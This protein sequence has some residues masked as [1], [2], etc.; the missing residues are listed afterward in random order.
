MFWRAVTWPFRSGTY[1]SIT[2]GKGVE[3]IGGDP[4]QGQLDPDEL[5]VGLALAVNTLLEAEFD[6]VVLLQLTL[7]VAGGLGVEVVELALQDGITWPGTFPAPRGL[8]RAG[9]GR[10]TATLVSIDAGSIGGPWVGNRSAR[11]GRIHESTKRHSGYAYFT[12]SVGYPGL[13]RASR[14]PC[15]RLL[16]GAPFGGC[17]SPRSLLAVARALWVANGPIWDVKRPIMVMDRG[18]KVGPGWLRPAWLLALELD[19]ERL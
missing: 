15:G 11:A 18:A 9:A 8:E 2:F 10:R 13:A 12:G 6:E 16:A 5:H 7:E 4:A 19:R 17:S 3:L 1:L 14:Q